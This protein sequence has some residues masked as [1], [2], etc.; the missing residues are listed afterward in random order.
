ML[1][2]RIFFYLWLLLPWNYVF[3]VTR[4]L[5]KIVGKLLVVLA[6]V[7]KIVGKVSGVLEIMLWD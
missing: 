2:E 3:L 6:V 1:L 5:R 4:V 7:D